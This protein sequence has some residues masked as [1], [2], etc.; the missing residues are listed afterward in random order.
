[1]ALINRQCLS[2]MSQ[3]GG[4]EQGGPRTSR[5]GPPASAQLGAAGGLYPPRATTGQLGHRA[6]ALQARGAAGTVRG[7]AAGKGGTGVA[8]GLVLR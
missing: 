5:R 2:S 7:Q 6:T 4:I 3:H 1:M 8:G